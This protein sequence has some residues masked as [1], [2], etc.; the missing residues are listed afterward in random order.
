MHDLALDNKPEELSNYL[1]KAK[2]LDPMFDI[3]K[4]DE[5]GY[6]TLHLAAD[7]GYTVVVQVL[8]QHA[9]KRDIKACNTDFTSKF[10]A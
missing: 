6:T 1:M 7:R 9:A 3:D 2:D 4:R 8:L 10:S 5:N